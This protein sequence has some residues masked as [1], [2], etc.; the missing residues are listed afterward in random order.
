MSAA[1][2][3]RPPFYLGIDLG[4]TNI[5]SGVVDDAGPGALVGQRRRPRPSTGRRPGSTTWPR[6]AGAPSRPSGADAGT[7]R[8]RRARFARDDGPPGGHAPRAAEP[9]R[10]GATCRSA[11]GS[12]SGSASRPC[13][14]TTAMPRPTASTGPAPARTPA[15]WCCSRWAP[16][17]AAGSSIDG[18]IIEGRHSHGA[19]CGH[20]IIQMENGR[21]CSCGGYG[22]LEAY[23]SATA[24]V[25]RAHEALE[26][27]ATAQPAAA[28]RPREPSP[29]ERSPRRPRPATPW[30]TA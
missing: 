14:R 20:I 10:L 22:H 6:P 9:A 29:A 15:A 21:H 5:K 18:R 8:G 16:G 12:P 1:E 19:E 7:D 30:P 13:S 11:I 26:Q 3:G 17:S 24:L 25:K 23:A 28:A 27:I 4:G 2:T